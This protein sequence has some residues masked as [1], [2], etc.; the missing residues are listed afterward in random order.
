MNDKFYKSLFLSPVNCSE[1]YDITQSLKN[2]FS[3]GHD[4]ISSNLLKKIIRPI[5]IP[6]THIFNLSLSAGVYPHSFK[7]AKV[8][9]IHKKDDPAYISNY[10]PI[11]LLTSFSKILEKIVYKRVDKFFFKHP[12]TC[13]ILINM[14]FVNHI[15]PMLQSWNYTTEYRAP[16][17]TI[18]TS[19]ACLWT[20]AR[21]SILWI[22]RFS[23]QSCSIMV[24]GELLSIGFPAIYL[25][26]VNIYTVYYSC[27][28]ITLPLTCGVPQG[29]ILGPLLFLIYV[30][31]LINVSDL[32]QYILCLLMTPTYFIPMMIMIPWL[33]I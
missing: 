20:L 32:L 12:I 18:S 5:L 21:R 9:P 4:E 6:L 11:S 33:P 29:S 31:D 28:S 7:L 16:W 25:T 15:L 3:A 26:D 14:D 27:S 23:F 10:R 2:C 24:W 22:M 19:L 1:V 13:L 8:V 17:R 30:N